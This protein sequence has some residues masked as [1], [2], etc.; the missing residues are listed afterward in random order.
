MSPEP[1]AIDEAGGEG[2][3]MGGRGRE[4][5]VTIID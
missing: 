2:G 3:G 1:W 4:G 5:Y